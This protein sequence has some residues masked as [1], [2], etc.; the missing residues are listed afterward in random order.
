MVQNLN[1][2]VFF[3]GYQAVKLAQAEIEIMEN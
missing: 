3:K 1:S 2:S